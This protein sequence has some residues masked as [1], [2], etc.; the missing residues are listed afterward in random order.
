MLPVPD[1]E[2]YDVSPLHGFLPSSPPLECLPDSYYA[3]WEDAVK[4]LQGL[5]LSHRLREVVDRLPVLSTD[6]LTTEPEW[7]RAY[8]LLAFL[9]HGYIWGG[10]RP[11]ERIP[12]PLSIPFLATCKHLEL[13]PVA[14]YAGLVLWNWRPLFA[15]EPVDSL[16]NLD[17]L[18]T[19]TGA[20]D[21]RWF[22]LVSAAIEARGAP[23][24][25]I[26]LRA[27]Q[28]AREENLTVVTHCLQAFAERLDEL[29]GLLARM[30]DHC[31]PHVFYHRIRPFLAGSK[32]MADAGLPNG[33]IW[34]NG[35]AVNRQRY[36]QYS[37]GSN[38]QSSILQFF[39]IA[40]GVEHRPTGNSKEAFT[41][42]TTTTEPPTKPKKPSP[43]PTP[44]FIHDMRTYM[45]GPHARFLRAVA[46]VA[47]LREFV[48]AH[49]P[50]NPGLALA[51]DAGLAVLRAFRDTH[52]QIVS[53][54][55]IVPSRAVAAAA[56]KKPDGP[57]RQQ[58]QKQKINLAHRA[59]PDA[60]TGQKSPSPK[61]TG[62]TA[63]IPFLRQARDETGEPAV[64]AWTQRLLN[65]RRQSQS[66]GRADVAVLAAEEE[67]GAT[68][69]AAAAA[70]AAVLPVPSAAGQQRTR[71]D[72]IQGLAGCWRVDEFGGGG[73]CYF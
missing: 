34:D 66:G 22:Y 70:A 20:L 71:R 37:G 52:I 54:Y 19:F 5:L 42:T 7:R 68:A 33:V 2:D 45:P 64:H 53:R 56:A 65:Q 17:T 61:G 51:Y 14:T 4:N 13:P 48:A 69:A 24:I 10:A 25:P 59:H 32:N 28:A 73:L 35:G 12:P 39:D 72:S 55:I 38:A 27:I 16:A 58:Q 31:D 8:S 60:K 44:N 47:N 30:P 63:L 11:R 43:S 67:L 40:L 57:P 15:A 49:A 18:A 21:E 50:E 1:P 46:R 23:C 6:H 3:P 9:A 26:L 29:R 41:T 36:V 62:G